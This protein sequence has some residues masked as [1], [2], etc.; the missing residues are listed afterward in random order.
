[1]HPVR[2]YFNDPRIS[3]NSRAFHFGIDI[4]AKD[5]TPVY[6]VEEG[7]AHHGRGSRSVSVVARGGRTFGY[8]HIV[9]VVAHRKHV[10]KHQ[11]LG[12]VEA[13]WAHVHFAESY[14]RVYRNP[15]RPGA[16]RPWVDPTTPRIVAIRFFRRGR[17]L[18]PLDVAG[19]VDVVVEAWDKPP[20]RPPA[21]WH[22]MPV[23]PALLRWRVLRGGKTVRPWRAPV[24]FRRNLLPPSL[25][26]IVYAPGT[27]QNKPPKPGRYCFFVAHGWS[28]TLLPN[29]LY[30]V[31][32]HAADAQG[33]S[34][35][36][37]IPFT[38][39]N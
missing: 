1:M 15:L 34:A 16:L 3:G 6:A 2:G 11:L 13:P 12:H 30:R 20:L 36:S 29:G 32:V 17:E 8:W 27:R 26:P 22:D 4:S 9:P 28:T 7:E 38:I 18:S 35:R 33:N 21:P 19:D 37:G 5:G 10:R 23:T 39:S 14:R 31:E 25:F 24:D